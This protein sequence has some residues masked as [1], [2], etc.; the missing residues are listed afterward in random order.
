MHERKSASDGDRF[1]WDGLMVATLGYSHQAQ[2]TPSERRRKKFPNSTTAIP[3]KFW[4]RRHHA[5]MYL[6]MPDVAGNKRS[7]ATPRY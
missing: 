5:F 1:G 3:G 7:I 4:R 6:F 2:T